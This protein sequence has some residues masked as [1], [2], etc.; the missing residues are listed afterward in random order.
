MK[1]IDI[2]GQRFC[3]LI[4]VSF[5]GRKKK[6]SFW[7]VLCDCGNKKEV[8]G[9]H[10]KI[11]DTK[12]CGCL[13]KEITTKHG[14]SDSRIYRIWY[15]M[16][17]RCNNEKNHAYKHYGGRGV[18]VCKRW[19]TF[20]KFASDM[21]RPPEKFSLERIDVNGNYTKR[22]CKWASATEQMNN[23]RRNLNVLLIKNGKKFT[24][25]QFAKHY[26]IP[27]STVHSRYVRGEYKTITKGDKNAI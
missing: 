27:Y 20:K 22:N 8:E 16:M 18:K 7:N 3:R 10:L 21:G 1:F 9:H 17:Q 11:G 12:S 2:T 25:S 23:T 26:G 13:H 14:L 15:A 5:A 19:L 4:V 24:I 6:K